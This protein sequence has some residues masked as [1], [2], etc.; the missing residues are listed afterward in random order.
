MRTN[1]RP[2]LLP[3]PKHGS[4]WPLHRV[5]GQS[6][7]EF[8]I[9]SVVLFPLLFA[10]ILLMLN[11]GQAWSVMGHAVEN[12]GKDIT[13]S[14]EYD[15]GTFLADTANWGAAAVPG[16]D[17]L[18]ITVTAADGSGACVYGW[19]GTGACGDFAVAYGD[20]VSIHATKKL[21]LGSVFSA[22]VDLLPNVEVS[23]NGIAQRNSS[24][25]GAAC[26]E[27]TCPGITNGTVTGTV[28][29]SGT[30]SGISGVLLDFGGGHL[31]TSGSSGQYSRPNLPAANYTVTVS[32]NGYQ[33][34]T[35]MVNVASGV[36]TALDFALESAA[37]I[38]ITAT[39]SSQSNL[40]SNGDFETGDTTS[41]DSGVG[42]TAFAVAGSPVFD[43]SFVGAVTVVTTT[44][45]GASQTLDGFTSGHDYRAAV[46]VQGEAGAPLSLQLGS[47]SDVVSALGGWQL[48]QVTWTATSSSASISVNED[49]EVGGPINATFYFD[50]AEVEDTANTVDNATVTTGS[51]LT[52][53]PIGNGHYSLVVAYG[54]VTIRVTA[55]VSGVAM[56]G[57]A[58]VSNAS[59]GETKYVYVAIGNP[60]PACSSY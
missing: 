60:E 53:T 56:T 17:I 1:P 3:A 44:G 42:V 36:T 12:L 21:D 20:L 34:A 31:A 46:W 24:N 35:A 29:D 33:T 10:L 40:V 19:D 13:T 25:G 15:E 51:G 2:S 38:D 6:L 50:V 9:V 47:E 32:K 43:G 59:A 8:A 7:V 49:S 39:T 54:A 18:D 52:A 22:L 58:T 27:F 55:I 45:G 28:R 4:R 16:V 23:W 11:L 41:W 5:S 14:G 30:G 37:L 57:C 48:L 26:S